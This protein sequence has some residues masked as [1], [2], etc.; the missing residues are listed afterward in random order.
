MS[1]DSL[2]LQREPMPGLPWVGYLSILVL[3]AMG[4]F[5]VWRRRRQEMGN[6]TSPL[7]F[8]AW[9]TPT[10]TT[11]APLQL[12]QT[13]RVAPHTVLVCARW[14]QDDLLLAVGPQGVQLLARTPTNAAETQ[15]TTP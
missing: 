8:P 2:P 3:A 4:A 12:H 9:L 10:P 15:E 7:K 11:P 6:A 14:K 1:F 13:L 5:L